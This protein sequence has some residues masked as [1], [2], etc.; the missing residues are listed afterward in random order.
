MQADVNKHTEDF[1]KAHPDPAKLDEKS[2]GELRKIRRE[3][4]EVAELLEELLE[5]P[6]EGGGD[7]P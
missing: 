5:P 2:K 4:Q 3:Q 1:R 6:D 7:K